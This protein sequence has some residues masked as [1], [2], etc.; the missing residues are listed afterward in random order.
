M[1]LGG[2]VPALTIRAEDPFV[3]IPDKA[4]RY[5]YNYRGYSQVLDY[6]LITSSLEAAVNK[7]MV[8]HFNLDYPFST[9]RYDTSV[10]LCS[11]DHD[12]VLASFNI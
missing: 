12:V 1:L 10:G 9:Y 3:S 5:T 6:I 11:S 2:F 8:V 7:I 4:N